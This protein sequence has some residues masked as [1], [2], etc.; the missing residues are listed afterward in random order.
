[1]KAT[2]EVMSIGRTYEES[3]LKAIRSLEYGVHHLG[4][5]NGESFD[6]EYIKARIQ[7]QDDERLFFIGEAIRRGT[8]LEELHEMTK[9]DYFFLNKFKN[10]IDMEHAQRTSRRY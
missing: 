1:M 7:A 10:I 4:L 9:I 3:L 2:G 6:L 5:P 8:T